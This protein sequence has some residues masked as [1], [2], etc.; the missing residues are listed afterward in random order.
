MPPDHVLA[1][2][3]EVAIELVVVN[4]EAAAAPFVSPATLSGDL[5]VAQQSW[6]V[7][8]TA[9]PSLVQSVI[10]PAGFGLFTGKDFDHTSVQLDLTFPIRTKLLHFETYLLFQYFNGYGESLLSYRE[11]AETLRAGISL[12]R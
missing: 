11:K 10:R 12:V 6:P 4:R 5:S 1:A 3:G 9:R 2:G 8:L 7:Q